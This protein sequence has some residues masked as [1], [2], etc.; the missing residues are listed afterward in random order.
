MLLKSPTLMAWL[1]AE[2]D[3]YTWRPHGGRVM[4]Q[5]GLLQAGTPIDAPVMYAE[6]DTLDSILIWDGRHRITAL[7]ELGAT[8][9]PVMVPESQVELF[10]TEFG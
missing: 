6:R 1:T 2:R 8:F 10:V 5:I 4:T 9:I 3:N 7:H